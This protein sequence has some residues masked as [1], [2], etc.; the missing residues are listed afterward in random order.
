MC[1]KRYCDLTCSGTG[2][3]TGTGIGFTVGTDGIPV[4]V[5]GDAAFVVVSV[6]AGTPVARRHATVRFFI[7]AGTGTAD[8]V[9]VILGIDT[10][11]RIQATAQDPVRTS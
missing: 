9:G 11:Q 5:V 2:T 4:V 6:R 1:N 8:T 3:G 7:R 10:H